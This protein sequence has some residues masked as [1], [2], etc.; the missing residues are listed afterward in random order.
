MTATSSSFIDTPL[1]LSGYMSG[2]MDHQQGVQGLPN[3]QQQQQ[4]QCQSNVGG[5]VDGTAAGGAQGVSMGVGSSSG[6]DLLTGLAQHKAAAGVG[7]DS[8][9]GPTPRIA[10]AT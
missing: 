6:V 3:T 7:G 10:G 4:Q 9:V 8:S 1:S 5:L 2:E